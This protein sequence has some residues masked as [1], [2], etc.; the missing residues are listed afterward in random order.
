MNHYLQNQLN[1]IKNSKDESYILNCK[2]RIASAMDLFPVSELSPHGD[3]TPE[4]ITVVNK[5][6]KEQEELWT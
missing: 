1:K 5:F 3:L 2:W 6:I 4:Q